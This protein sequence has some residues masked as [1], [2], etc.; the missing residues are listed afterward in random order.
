MDKSDA[1]RWNEILEHDAR[2]ASVEE[3]RIRTLAELES[4]RKCIIRNMYFEEVRLFRCYAGY[5]TFELEDGRTMILREGEALI[6]Y[7][8]HRV[9]IAAKARQNRILYGVF[10]GRSAVEYF[11]ALGF[12]DL[13]Q[14]FTHPQYESMGE[15]KRRI[16]CECQ[17]EAED[18]APSAL[19][20]LTDIL[21]SMVQD[22]RSGSCALVFDA[23]R[24]IRANL[25]NRVV[26]VEPLCRDLGVSRSHLHSAFK[27]L[28][29][30][31]PAEFI[32]REQERLAVSL[33]E[34][35]RLTI[36]EV[37]ERTGFLSVPHFSTFIRKRV[38]QTPLTIRMRHA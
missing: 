37:A 6:I 34:N 1:L 20:F 27:Q 33:L 16:E 29:I 5:F 32:R 12:F 3:V 4:P 7:P 28:G 11:D 26:R 17:E 19:S 23:V 15:L 9:T 25:K 2:L 30:P 13:A 38:G 8:K 35:T 14:G 36:A 31:P 22:L 24:K 10:D 18:A 21:V